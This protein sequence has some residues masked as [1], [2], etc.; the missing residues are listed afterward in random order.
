MI[1]RSP[2]PPRPSFVPHRKTCQRFNDPGHA[3]R[4]TFF[5]YRRQPFLTADRRRR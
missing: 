4:L 5:C 1:C 2:S 3:H